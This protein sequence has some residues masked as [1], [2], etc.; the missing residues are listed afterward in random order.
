MFRALNWCNRVIIGMIGVVMV[1]VHVCKGVGN[2]GVTE[3]HCI[4]TA[5]L[6]I[7]E[8]FTNRSLCV[9]LFIN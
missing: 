1:P 5:S 6:T 9:I 4:V 8:G 2:R 7:S 3:Y